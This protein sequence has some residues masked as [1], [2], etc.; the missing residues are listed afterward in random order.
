MLPSASADAW[1][2]LDARDGR[3]LHAH[4]ETAEAL[5]GS[6]VKPFLP[7]AG[8]FPCRRELR[9]GAQRL[10]CSHPPLYG[11]IERNDALVLSCNCYFAQWALTVTPNAIRD[12]LP[13]FAAQMAST[14]EQRQLQALGHWGVTTSALRLARA[15]RRIAF[16]ETGRIL[17][18]GKSGTTAM[19]AW[20]AGW[21]PHPL[22]QVIV[23]VLT[24]GRGMVN[25]KP[26]AEELMRRW[27]R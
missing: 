5:P 2:V 17:G 15:Y 10:D 27:L 21:A 7:A 4:R 26:A 8:R 11:A 13:D 22:P 9:V 3:V 19:G 25:A 18:G 6:T 12:A 16:H 14:A 20:Y 1:C 23:A 24:G